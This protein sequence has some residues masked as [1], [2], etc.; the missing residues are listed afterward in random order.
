MAGPRIDEIGPW[1]EVKLD[2]LKRYAVEYSKILSNQKDPSLFHVYIDA[3]A[4]AGFHLSR[5]SGEWV[6]G[7][8][9]N[10]LLVQPPFREY[11]LVDLDGDKVQGLKQ[12]IGERNDVLIH[13]GDC[14]EVLLKEVFPRVRYRDYRRGLCLLDPYGLTLDWRVIREAG[15]M[16]SLDIFINFPIY[17]ININV[18]HHDP[19]TVLR[20]HIERMT[21]YWGDE[22]WREVAYDKSLGLFGEMEEKVSNRR[23]AEA[24]RQRLKNVAGFA[25]VPEPLPMRNSNR[26]IVYYLFFASQKGT[27]EDIVTHIFDKFGR[28]TI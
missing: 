20:S 4:G 1:S 23:F 12:I 18:L 19:S 2:I 22:S 27:A 25:R 10:A 5:T 26:S 16:R 17:D 8:P 15:A 3:F 11:H 13:Q 7:S 28:R 24:F 9:L 21:A 6:L 14:N